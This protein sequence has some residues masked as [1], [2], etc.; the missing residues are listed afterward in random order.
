MA[1]VSGDWQVVICRLFVA[2]VLIECWEPWV[3]YTTKNKLMQFAWTA[4]TSGDKPV[5]SCHSL[6][7][8]CPDWML[9]ILSSVWNN[10][11]SFWLALKRSW[12]YHNH[13]FILTYTD[14]IAVS[15]CFIEARDTKMK[16]KTKCDIENA[17]K[18]FTGL[19]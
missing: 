7:W 3:P 8:C 18:Y 16:R 1:D 14:T 4:D 2:A 11:V 15:M 12:T 5:V 17:K 10:L 19:V 13:F 9:R 6:C